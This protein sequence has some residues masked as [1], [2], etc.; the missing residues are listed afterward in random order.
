MVDFQRQDELVDHILNDRHQTY[1]HFL[2]VAAVATALRAVI[3]DRR[4]D[5]FP[6]QDEA[7]NMICVKIARIVNGD[8]NHLDSWRDIAGYAQLVVDRLEGRSR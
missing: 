6:D 3:R 4:P 1:G 2:D 7:L 8:P 5:L